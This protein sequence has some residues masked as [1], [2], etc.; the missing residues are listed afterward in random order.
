MKKTL[1]ALLAATILSACSAPDEVL[2]EAI[3]AKDTA[4]VERIIAKGN[5]NLDPPQQPNQV[6]KPLAFAAAYGNL[7]VVKLILEGGADINGQVAYGDTALIK[8][9]EHDNWD[10]A[11]YLIEQG[12]DVNQPNAFGVSPF[13]GFCALG[14]TDLVQLALA[15]GG[16]VNAHFAHRTEQNQG[17]RNYTALQAAVAYGKTDVVQILL[18][19]GGDP[20]I[21]DQTGKTSL[22]LAREKGHAD[23]VDLFE[24]RAP[25]L[26]ARGA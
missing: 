19:H 18:E 24:G 15:K 17:K 22:E 4:H 13:I 12:A 25:G 2:F 5:V 3:R 20:T 6:N 16:K 10:V 7:E 8:A 11:T 21:R 9:V 1:L 14:R 23:I 26:E